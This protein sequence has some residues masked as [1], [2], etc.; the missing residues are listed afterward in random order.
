MTPLL[1]KYQRAVRAAEYVPRIGNVRQYLGAVV[2]AAGPDTALGE[3][4]EIYPPN[5][6]APVIAETVGFRHDSVLLM[7]YADLRGIRPGSEIVA[8]GRHAQVPVGRAL[9]GR[10]IDAF[11]VPM[12]GRKLMGLED[13]R[14]LF[15]EPVNPMHRERIVKVFETGVRAIDSLLTVGVGQR[16]GIFAGSGVGKSALMGMIAQNS[17]SDVNVVALIGER[18][19]ELR[20][21]IETNLGS[22]LKKTVVIVATAEQS[23]LMRSHAAFSATAIAEYFRDQG[24]TVTLMLDSLTRFA[25]ARREIGL[26]VGEPPTARGYTPSVF[27]TL[28]TLLERTGVGQR[29][30]GSITAF[31]T[32]LVEGD[33]FNEPIS[34]HVR[35]ILDGHLVLSREVANRG[36]YPAVD[37]LK[38]ISRLLPQIVSK[39]EQRLVS[40]TLAVLGIYESSRDMVEM[41]AY[42]AGTNAQLDQALTL[43]PKLEAFL[44]QP[45]TETMA[46]GA[47][48]DELRRLLAGAST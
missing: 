15:A 44:R 5:K 20:D 3:L 8:T 24:L 28:P 18:G 32:V 43:I 26:A 40:Q 33:D 30:S 9:L 23:P 22:A 39:D 34:D 12:D 16:I 45:T 42:K 4:C 41:G 27:T 13:S 36:R 21:F 31:Y 11:G 46:R 10:V 38:S 17:S 29:N 1:A 19:R 2:E 37:V 7:P 14:P 48:I 25:M 47:A 35:A 6:L